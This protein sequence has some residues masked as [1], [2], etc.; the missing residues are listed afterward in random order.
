MIT[1]T[2]LSAGLLACVFSGALFA[3]DKS[4]ALRKTSFSPLAG[5]A[6]AKVSPLNSNEPLVF[7]APPRESSEE[8]HKLYQP[9]ADYLSRV[10]G[11]RVSYVYPRNWLLYQKEMTKGSYDIVFDGSHFNSWRILHLQHNTVAKVPEQQMFKVVTRRDNT[12]ITSL[13]QLAGKKV[14]GMG[15]SN[16]GTLALQSE[17]DPSRQPL[18]VEHISWT[19]VYEAVMEN[20]CS[21]G[22]VSVAVLRKLDG[23]SNFTRV[24][25]QSRQLPNQAF[26]AGP[27]VTTEEQNKL[28]RALTSAEAH[29]VLEP[30]LS[31]NGVAD[32]GLVL[33]SKEDFAGMDAY[34]KDVWGYTR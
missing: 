16:L 5:E 2:R 17:F 28:A 32:S 6:A 33:A 15:A 1:F 24:I 26:S 18:I 29:K 23:A 12:Q 30:M 20:R 3:V 9:V 19:K 11:R 25:H 34:L 27:R 7:S 14:C 13:K 22:I 31:A 21:A 4:D 8:A 10:T